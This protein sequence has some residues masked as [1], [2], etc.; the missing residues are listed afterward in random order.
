MIKN[1]SW[2]FELNYF[3]YNCYHLV[4]TLWYLKAW[5]RIYLQW[6]D[7]VYSVFTVKKSCLV[8][9]FSKNEL[10]DLFGLKYYFIIHIV[11]FYIFIIFNNYCDSIFNFDLKYIFFLLFNESNFGG[12]GIFFF[13]KSNPPQVLTD[14]HLWL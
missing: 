14:G 2:I 1:I 4:S 11:A 13:W 3:L 10:E 6:M 12:I 8:P 5:I 7:C 9:R